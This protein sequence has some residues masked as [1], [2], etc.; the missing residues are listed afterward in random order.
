MSHMVHIFNRRC[1]ATSPRFGMIHVVYQDCLTRFGISQAK[2]QNA[3]RST[4]H[5]AVS[6]SKELS[7]PL[8]ISDFLQ[9]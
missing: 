9:T 4:I 3:P 1:L 7:T 6:L 8:M 5:A 2:K